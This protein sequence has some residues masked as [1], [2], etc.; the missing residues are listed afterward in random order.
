MLFIFCLLCLTPTLIHTMP[1]TLVLQDTDL[2]GFRYRAF[3]SLWLPTE[4]CQRETAAGQW[5]VEG[6][7]GWVMYFPPTYICLATVLVVVVFCG[8]SFCPAIPLLRLQTVF[9]LSK[10]Y[11]P[12]LWFWFWDDNDSLQLLIPGCFTKL[13]CSLNLAH[14]SLDNTFIELSQSQPLCLP[15]FSC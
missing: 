7:R 2:H 14:T 12:F 8:Y 1:F 13:L 11:F 5:K 15:L 4:F 9:R 10:C 3:F 6:E